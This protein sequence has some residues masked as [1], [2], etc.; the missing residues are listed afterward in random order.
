MSEY[1]DTWIFDHSGP[2]VSDINKSINLIPSYY[3]TEITN[4]ELYEE[5]SKPIDKQSKLNDKVSFLNR[6]YGRK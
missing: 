5:S 6:V 2:I 3:P 4:D 1:F